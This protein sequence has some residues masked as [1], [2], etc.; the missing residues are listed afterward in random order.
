MRKFT[1]VEK[2]LYNTKCL[3]TANNV[4]LDIVYQL[5]INITTCVSAYAP[6]GVIGGYVVWILLFHCKPVDN[7]PRHEKTNL[8]RLRKSLINSKM[9]SLLVGSF[10][11]HHIN[12]SRKSIFWVKTLTFSLCDSIG[13]D[14]WFDVGHSL[15]LTCAFWPGWI[16]A[17]PSTNQQHWGWF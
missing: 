12:F 3:Q 7:S 9:R 4:W 5:L 13:G 1:V 2:T 16:E 14:W 10:H 8:A 15:I 6:A 11:L 17:D